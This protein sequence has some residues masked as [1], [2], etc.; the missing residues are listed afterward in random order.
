VKLKIARTG[1]NLSRSTATWSIP[2]FF[3]SWIF[4]IPWISHHRLC[5]GYVYLYICRCVH[6]KAEG[7]WGKQSTMPASLRCRS[8]G[9]PQTQRKMTFQLPKGLPSQMAPSPSSAIPAAKSAHFLP[10]ISD[11]WHLKAPAPS[12]MSSALPQWFLPEQEPGMM[13]NRR[14]GDRTQH[15]ENSLLSA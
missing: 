10:P 1:R 2:H 9:T 13:R 8:N 11:G 6:G 14:R 5:C 3:R 4:L 7:C 12:L 15:P